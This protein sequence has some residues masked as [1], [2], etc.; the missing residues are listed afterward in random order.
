MSKHV[1]TRVWIDNVNRETQNEFVKFMTH[2]ACLG[3]ELEFIRT[4]T[5]CHLTWGKEHLTKQQADERCDF[6]WKV[7]NSC[8]LALGYEINCENE[9]VEESE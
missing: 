1:E 8:K 2:E 5:R 3:V 6:A 9:V 7:A 4:P